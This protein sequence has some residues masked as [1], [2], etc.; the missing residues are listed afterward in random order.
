MSVAFKIAPTPEKLSEISSTLTGYWQNDV[1]DTTDSVFDD[2]RPEKWS[3]PNNTI[4]LSILPFALR[5]EVKFFFVKRLTEQSLRLL[6]VVGYGVCFSRLAKFLSSSYPKVTSFVDI[7]LDKAI[8]K[9]RSYLVGQGMKVGKEGRLVT[10]TYE[11]IL[12][13]LCSFFE[14][15]YDTRDE[16]EKDIWDLRKIPGTKITNSKTHYLLNF[17]GT[18]RPFVKLVKKFLKIRVGRFSQGDCSRMLGAL[19]LFLI[20]ILR[21]HSSWDSLRDLNR[22]DIED[23][24]SWYKQFSEGLT[25]ARFRP[26]TYLRTFLQYIQRAEYPEAPT[27]PSILLLW[28]EDIPSKPISTENSLK[29]IPEEILQQLDDNLEC[30]GSVYVPIVILLR[31]SGWRISDIFNLRYNT[32]LD[33]TAQGWWLCGDIPKTQVLDH[34]VPITDEI[35]AIVQAVVEA[36]KEKSTSDNNPKKYLFVRFDGKRKGRPPA[37]ITV[38]NALNRLANKYNIIDNQGILYHFGNHAFRHTKGVELINNGMNVLHVQKWM[39]HASPE[40]TLRYAKI[41]DNTMRKSWEEAMKNGA[42]RLDA[43]GKPIKV[44]VSA[45]ENEEIIEW[46]YIR[47]NLDAVRMPLGYCLKP[48]KIECKHQLNPCLTCRNLC[49]TPDFI[50]Q[51]ELE[52]R[53]V[54]TLIE[55]GKAQ[56]QTLWVEKNQRLLDRYEAMLAVLKEGKTHHLAGKKGREYVGEERQNVK[57]SA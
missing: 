17:T 36:V 40:M 18:P 2:M 46:E 7:P 52:V 48:K 12:Q 13:Q 28:K 19:N 14:S 34:R 9:W 4:N 32:C 30:L 57:P 38:Q 31:A 51:Y 56:N 53:E 41:L 5:D 3:I 22:T 23:Y 54:R 50:P 55:R 16:F 33:R 24:L 35:A 45:I 29:F 47:H 15:Y 42:F 27:A 44:D 49:T 1:W 11:T 8:V 25:T 21:K 20:F 6:T 43:D 26:I 10:K 39:A 37:G